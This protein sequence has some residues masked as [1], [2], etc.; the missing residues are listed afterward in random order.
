MR[1][2]SHAFLQT[3]RTLG[4]RPAACPDRTRSADRKGVRPTGGESVGRCAEIPRSGPTTRQRSP[5]GSMRTSANP[6]RCCIR[7]S[8][9][10]YSTRASSRGHSPSRPRRT[11]RASG[12]GGRVQI[13]GPIGWA[14]ALDRVSSREQR[15]REQRSVDEEIVR[16]DRDG[17]CTDAAETPKHLNIASLNAAK[18]G[19]E[20]FALRE[21]FLPARSGRYRAP[22]L[23]QRVRAIARCR[24]HRLQLADRYQRAGHGG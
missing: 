8:P 2:G 22:M 18:S 20:A 23:A 12:D 9:S 11:S 4:T 10:I 16:I 19:N 5:A 14:R 1:P 3:R 21:G 17:R 6:T 15:R 13:A 24:R 7:A